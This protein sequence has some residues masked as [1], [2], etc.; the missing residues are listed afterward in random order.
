MCGLAQARL[1]GPRLKSARTPFGG[2]CERRDNIV[3][4]EMPS[5]HQSPGNPKVCVVILNWN[6]WGDTIECLES[7]FRLGYPNFQVVVCDNGSTDGSVERIKAWAD[8]ALDV[9][10][11]ADSVHRRL[12]TPPVGKPVP[13]VEYDR[14]AAEAA[15]APDAAP[16][17]VII[18]TGGNLGYSGGNNVGIRY[19]LRQDDVAF[20]WLLNND[21]V[22]DQLALDKLVARAS[23]RSAPGI[24]GSTLAYYDEPAVMQ[25]AGGAYYH[26]FLGV[27]EL[28]SHLEPVSRIKDPADIERRLSYVVGASMLIRRDLL[29]KIGLLEERYFL[30]YEEVDYATRAKPHASLGYAPDSLVYHKVGR[31]TGSGKLV[32]NRSAAAE[33]LMFR[34]RVLF[35]R[36]FHPYALPTVYLVLIGV[37]A[38]R[39]LSR[40]WCKVRSVWKVLTSVG[41]VRELT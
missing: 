24:V 34:A 6:G 39:L 3:M 20:V 22:V 36:K 8:G 23:A 27:S 5:E 33:F 35:I 18:R 9:A 25:A 1:L 17:L 31:S 13:Y 30:F 26:P 4:T 11:P 29:E 40:E 28:A 41:S 19:A 16:P 7:V 37:M 38:W 21:T 2:G 14:P 15:G 12:T 10:M 32:K